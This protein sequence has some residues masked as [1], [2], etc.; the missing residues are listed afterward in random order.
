[1]CGRRGDC[2]Q[3]FGP[4]KRPRKMAL[5]AGEITK[6][7]CGRY[8]IPALARDPDLVKGASSKDQEHDQGPECLKP[9]LSIHLS[10]PEMVF[11]FSWRA[12]E[13]GACRRTDSMSGWQTSAQANNCATPF[14]RAE[15]PGPNSA[16]ATCRNCRKSAASMAGTNESRTAGKSSRCDCSSIWRRNKQ[17]HYFAT[18]RR[19]RCIATAIC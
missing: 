8:G 12:V 17:S 13:V 4:N 5:L 9:S 3:L 18:A 10:N 14:S 7:Q 19:M 11:G 2:K 6:R 15:S 16:G 1:M